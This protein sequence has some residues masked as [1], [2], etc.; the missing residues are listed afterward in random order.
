M[1][2]GR[3]SLQSLVNI[4]SR[5]TPGWNH[6]APTVTLKTPLEAD[7][8]LKHQLEYWY[9]PATAQKIGITQDIGVAKVKVTPI[10]VPLPDGGA[11][12]C[13]AR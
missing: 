2:S 5:L 8:C 12:A 9:T 1:S 6:F 11:I 4:G 10:L 3:G 7:V 13:G